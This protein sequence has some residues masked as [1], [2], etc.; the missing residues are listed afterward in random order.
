MNSLERYSEN[1]QREQ[2]ICAKNATSALN[3]WNNL[4]WQ[5]IPDRNIMNFWINISTYWDGTFFTIF[6]F[7]FTE[8]L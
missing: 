4:N 8:M 1:Q 5:E 3:K 6:D 7:E 2:S